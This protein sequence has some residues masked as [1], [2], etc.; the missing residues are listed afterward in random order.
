MGAPLW[1]KFCRQIQPERLEETVV[2]KI[3][4]TTYPIAV[5]CSG[6]PDS[7]A[8]ALVTRA[9]AKV[10]V[11]L[12][13]FD[14][15]LRGRAS[16]QDAEFVR[17]LAKRIGADFRQGEWD[18][19]NKGNET[20]A[21]EARMA[22]LHQW[23]HE[24]IVFGH[25]ADDAAETFLMRLAR[26]ASITGLCAPHPINRVGTHVHLRPLLPLRKKEIEAAL[27][28]CK[29]KWRKDHTNAHNDY[30]R[31]RIR[32]KLL[33]LWQKIETR[34]VVEGILRTQ[35]GL[36]KLPAGAEEAAEGIPENE[37]V[38]ECNIS[39]VLPAG[40]LLC[41]PWGGILEARSSQA[42]TAHIRKNSS[43]F[44]VWIRNMGPLFVRGWDPGERYTPFLA[45]GSRKVKELLNENCKD[46][47]PE[48]RAYW[49]MVVDIS[50]KPLW[51]PG[52]RIASGTQAVS[53]EP[54]IELI[55]RETSAK[56]AKE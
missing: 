27:R 28:T 20:L 14:H 48:I 32:N 29:I 1:D 10:P 50:G 55:F 56:M 24:C 51:I 12:L 11:T 49:P 15:R 4:G 6:G 25:H 33:P 47:A 22:F 13:H 7:V 44:H 53:G 31:N 45:P 23:E 43:Q 54:A 30:L 37:F 41:L 46:V 38:G 35:K 3:R 26:G 42:D 18:K 8:A 52:L 17:E 39:G 34:D 36:R 2:D 21:R 5:A 9:L 40:G 19:P 16:R